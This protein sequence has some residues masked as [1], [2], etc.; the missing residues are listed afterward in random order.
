L[1]KVHNLSLNDNSLE[2]LPANLFTSQTKMSRLDLGKNP[3][4]AF[5]VGVFNGLPPVPPNPLDPEA[6]LLISGILLPSA[7]GNV[8]ATPAERALDVTWSAV[9]GAHYY[10]S[11]KRADAD[12]WAPAAMTA[13]SATSYTISNLSQGAAYDVRVSALHNVPNVEP[14]LGLNRHSW[15]AR[16]ARGAVSV[17]LPSVPQ[18]LS[19]TPG[20]GELALSW[21]PPADTGGAS[22]TTYNLRW[23]EAGGAFAPADAAKTTVTTY[24]LTGLTNGA[25]YEVEIAASNITG[26]SAWSAPVSAALF[27]ID[28]N[29]DGAVTAADGILIARYLLGVTSGDG[30]AE[31]QAGAGAAA[32]IAADI[33]NGMDGMALDVDGNGAVN[34][35]DGIL[36]ARYLL[37][38]RGDALT[39]GF[40]GLD[41]DSIGGKIDALRP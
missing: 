13:L 34:A 36:T 3:L 5:P 18:N 28:V 23:K 12:V 20:G 11:W 4:T 29:R 16:G 10:L 37:G 1:T 31:G 9:S 24:T 22:A 35:T 39:M 38:L 17:G 8:R 14:G 7:P 33:Q 15:V 19:A 40:A 2:T 27:G 26:D 41:A 32:Q 21:E 30:L 25:N 6:G